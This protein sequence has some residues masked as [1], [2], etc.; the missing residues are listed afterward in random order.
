VSGVSPA[1]EPTPE[2]EAEIVREGVRR[3]VALVD[4]DVVGAYLGAAVAR[5]A[6]EADTSPRA[7][8]E[9]MLEAG[10]FLDGEEWE[11][12]ARNLRAVTR[13]TRARF[14]GVGI[15]FA[16]RGPGNLN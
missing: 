3:H 2:Q 1:G 5:I 12:V 7:V 14:A 10:T 11:R 9:R 8:V 6:L 4:G 13:L 16:R 15:T